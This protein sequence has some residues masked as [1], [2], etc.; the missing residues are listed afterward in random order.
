VPAPSKQQPKPRAH[1]NTARSDTQDLDV[2]G[3]NTVSVKV[4]SS[5]GTSN[6]ANR[7]S[8]VNLQIN[9]RTP[10][11]KRTNLSPAQ[12]R[13]DNI[14][15]LTAGKRADD[16]ESAVVSASVSVSSTDKQ[17]KTAGD[18]RREGVLRKG[19]VEDI[20]PKSDRRR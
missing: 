15:V 20:D 5:L 1:S 4:S 9:P 10:S 19:T 7:K 6:N 8:T 12:S 2:S 18:H 3:S 14:R 13:S 11:K 16:F 17:P